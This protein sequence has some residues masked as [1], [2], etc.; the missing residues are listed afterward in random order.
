[1]VGRMCQYVPRN[2]TGHVR[3][4]KS[5]SRGNDPEARERQHVRFPGGGG[6]SMSQQV[7]MFVEQGER[8][9]EV[10]IEWQSE[11]AP[12]LVMDSTDGAHVMVVDPRLSERQV[13]RA[14]VELGGLGPVVLGAWRERLGVSR[15]L[16]AS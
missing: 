2:R 1:M 9:V 7:E 10:R 4:K 12:M 5:L 8:Q 3:F 13:Q 15:P 11:G 16:S 6:S 14:I